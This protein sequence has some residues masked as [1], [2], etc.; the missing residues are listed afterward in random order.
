MAGN[1]IKDRIAI[2]GV[3]STGFS[4]TNQRSALAL[5]LDAATHAIRDA[6]LGARDVDGV[7]A[8]GE[9]GAP[10]PQTFAAALGLDTVK[11]WTRPAPVIL[12]AI[13]DAMNAIF[14]GSADT[15]LVVA[16]ML[17]RPSAAHGA[18]SDPLRRGLGTSD[19]GV[20]ER[21]ALA[22]AYAAWA[23][24][25]LHE[26]GGSREAWGRIAING[27]SNAARNPLAALRTPL[28]LADY[29][30]ARMIREPLSLLDMDLPVDGADAFVLTSA[31]RARF[32]PHPP[33]L[34]HAV[35]TGMVGENTE[36][37][38]ASLARH[39]QHV[40]VEQLRAKGDFWIDDVDVYCPYDGFTVI[41]ASWIEN[42]GWCRPGEAD[43]F[44]REHWVEAE[45][46]VRIRG[47]VPINPH[48]GS[49]S[50]GGTRGTG[51]L[52]EAV[53]QLRGAASERQVEN[54]RTALVT[55]GGFF[56]NSQGALLRRG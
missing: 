43:R 8:V 6:G 4:R 22:P 5:G 25:Y 26:L 52:R 20:P 40:V 45:S 9:P 46:R 39:G 30:S 54:A 2:V 49:L 7:I 47:R 32:L 35:A 16:S 56:F 34:L 48:G 53:L 13:A 28:T 31:E 18:A 51:H 12:F 38:L 50:E 14:A 21:I 3:G 37:Q 19:A 55:P 1:P 44:L 27:R 10:S 17:R 41:A 23:S 15:I 24:R 11:H 42:T 33:V 36:D 29:E